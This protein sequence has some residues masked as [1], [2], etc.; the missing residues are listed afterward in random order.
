[1]Q[2]LWKKMNFIYQ[3]YQFPLFLYS[4]KIHKCVHGEEIQYSSVYNT[5]VKNTSILFFFLKV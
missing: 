1:M 4:A 5:P 3:E 2:T